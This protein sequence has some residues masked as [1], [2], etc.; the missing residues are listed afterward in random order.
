MSFAGHVFDMINKIQ[1]NESLRKANRSSYARVK[2]EYQIKLNSSKFTSL[3]YNE[4]PK[5][6]LVKLKSQIRTEIIAAKRKSVI[7]NGLILTSA[8]VITALFVY[9]VTYL[10][11]VCYK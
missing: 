11:K 3:K 8:F 10:F 6:E 7:R 9:G 5:E 4:L 2:K 1:Y